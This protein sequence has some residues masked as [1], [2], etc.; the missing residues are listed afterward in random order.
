MFIPSSECYHTVQAKKKGL[1][2]KRRD[3][4]PDSNSGRGRRRS[5]VELGI[6]DAWGVL[7]SESLGKQLW[8]RSWQG[9]WRENGL[10]G[11]KE[12]VV[13]GGRGLVEC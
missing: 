7:E 5:L 2:S 11:K 8:D 13:E 9:G 12:D 4:T 3:Q 1:Q 10:E 6:W